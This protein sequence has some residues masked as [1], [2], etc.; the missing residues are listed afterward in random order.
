MIHH[1][2]ERSE[3]ATSLAP[4]PR[5]ERR[6]S[7]SAAGGNRLPI[8]AGCVGPEAFEGVV[9][10]RLFEEDVHDDVAVVEQHPRAAFAP[11]LGARSRV[12][13]LAQ[14]L[15]DR[16]DDRADLTGI[17]CTGDDEVVGDRDDVADF[18][19]DDVVA[20]LVVGGG[21]GNECPL[22]SVRGGSSGSSG[23]EV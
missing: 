2:R 5:P 6:A 21:G 3:Q 19:D 15:L 22:R 23:M 11:F 20:L 8:D 1:S 18:E 9:L 7:A 16:F 14:R 12:G 10:A 13:L 4:I 17:A